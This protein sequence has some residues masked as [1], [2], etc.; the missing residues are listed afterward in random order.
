MVNLF[1]G[2]I[3]CSECGGNIQVANKTGF[4]CKKANEKMGKKSK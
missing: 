4:V 3:F 1:Q 2:V